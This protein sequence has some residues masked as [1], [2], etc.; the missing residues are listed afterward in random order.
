M[1]KSMNRAFAVVLALVFALSVPFA[2]M[3][4]PA[5]NVTVLGEPVIWTDAEPFIDENDR[6]LVP[7]RAVGEALGLNVDWDEEARTAIFSSETIDEFGDKQLMMLT[8]PIGSQ[9]AEAYYHT[10]F[11]DGS[12]SS[13]S[14]VIPMDTAAVIVNDRTYAPIRYLAEF[15]GYEARWYEDS[16]TVAIEEMTFATDYD[17]IDWDVESV[18]HEEL[19][20][21]MLPGTDFDMV[22]EVEVTSVSVNDEPAE[23]YEMENFETVPEGMKLDDCYGICVKGDYT[24]PDDLGVVFDI[25]VR[26]TDY[27]TFEYSTLMAGFDFDPELYK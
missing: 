27:R 16:R 9:E 26:T 2:S 12:F 19:C 4:A 5:V 18:S 8:F 20:F 11:S 13:Y 17:L 25:V 1:K 21:I 7:L 23:F 14:E 6:T 24:D 3:A 15:F 10:T 22:R